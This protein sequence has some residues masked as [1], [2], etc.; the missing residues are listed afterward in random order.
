M[1]GQDFNCV[2]L[3][4]RRV[5]CWGENAAGQLGLGHLKPIGMTEVPVLADV[6]SVPLGGAPHGYSCLVITVLSE[7]G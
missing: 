7:H 1:A 5:K 2:V 3:D 4:T 6:P